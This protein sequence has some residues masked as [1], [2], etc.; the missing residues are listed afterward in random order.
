MIITSQLR[1][2]SI[3]ICSILDDFEGEGFE[4]SIRLKIMFRHVLK[5]FII[6]LLH[7]T[8]L[9]R[10]H[11]V[12]LFT[13]ACQNTSRCIYTQIVDESS[14]SKFTNFIHQIAQ[15]IT[16]RRSMIQAGMLQE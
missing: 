8:S 9:F 6:L 5:R 16:I 11:I 15:D 13:S 14:Y 12:E 4:D 7:S 10:S 2:T 3:R 1:L